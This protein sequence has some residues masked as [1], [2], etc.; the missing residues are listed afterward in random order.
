MAKNTLILF[1]ALVFT[2]VKAFGSVD[3]DYPIEAKTFYVDNTTKNIKMFKAS[4]PAYTVKSVIENCFDEANIG[5][6]AWLMTADGKTQLSVTLSYPEDDTRHKITSQEVAFYFYNGSNIFTDNNKELITDIEHIVGNYT[7][8]NTTNTATVTLTAPKYYFYTTNAYYQ[9]YVVIKAHFENGGSA[10]VA[11]SIGISRPG[12][13]ILHGLNDSSETFQPMKEYLVNSGQFISSQIFTVDYRGTNTSSFDDNTNK[14][15]VVEKGLKNLSNS[16]L[17]VGIASTKYDMVGHSMGGILE[18]L[19]N[20]EVDNQ[21]TNKL[22]TLNT[23]HFGAPLGNIAPILFNT[24]DVLAEANKNTKLFPTIST[25][26]SGIDFIFNPNDGRQAVT[27]LG[28]NSSAIQNLNS[29]KTARL[30]GIPVF[31]VGTSLDSK[32]EYSFIYSNPTTSTDEIIY[33]TDHLLYN[34]NPQDR[35]RLNYLFDEN[36][37][38]DAVVSVESQRGGLASQYCSIF[39][40]PLDSSKKV[41]FRHAYH[42]NSPKWNVTQNEIRLLLLSEPDE[43]IFCMNGFGVQQKTRSSVSTISEN[44]ASKYITELAEPKSTSYIHLNVSSAP[45]EGY[46]HTANISTSEDMLTTVVFATLS[47]DKMIA[48]YDKEIMNFNLEGYE[49]EV[50]FYAIGRTNYNALVIDSVKVNLKET[51]GIKKVFGNKIKVSAKN[52]NI[53]VIGASESYHMQ[54]SDMLGRT[55]VSSKSNNDNTYTIPTKSSLLFVTI[56]QN[57]KQQTYKIINN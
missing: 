22:I 53:R 47:N 23:P 9:Y 37:A 11:K 52:G 19:Y 40:D 13:I 26:K 17:H 39:L 31:A 3:N 8:D 12:V 32:E 38:S 5:K 7:T 27:D 20:Q 44:I 36:V 15:K 18:R 10:S 24:I 1:V 30:N 46:T 6:N 50:T 16:L 21:H 2:C 33:L 55:L 49:D 29:Y 35:K 28:I 14:Y 41:L 56:R 43:G 4:S 25:I 45:N 48:D 54:I 42:G 51:N 34:D 57:G